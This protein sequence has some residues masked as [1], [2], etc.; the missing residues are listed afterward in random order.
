MNS[1][2]N[3]LKKIKVKSAEIPQLFSFTEKE[4]KEKR[5]KILLK[6]KKNFKSKNIGI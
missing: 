5:K 6:I 1:K 4:F 3:T 2:A